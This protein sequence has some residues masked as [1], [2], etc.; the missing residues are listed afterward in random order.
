MT[1]LINE[2]SNSGS[3]WEFCTNIEDFVERFNQLVKT[4]SDAVEFVRAALTQNG[5]PSCT[6]CG[7]TEWEHPYGA[8]ISTCKNCN[9]KLRLTAGTFFR[10][11]KKLKHWVACIAM[12]HERIVFSQANFARAFKVSQSTAWATFHSVATVLSDA[13]N[14]DISVSASIQFIGLFMKRSKETINGL[15]PMSEEEGV[16]KVLEAQREAESEQA[17]KTDD[18]SAIELDA[19]VVDEKDVEVDID[20]DID[21]KSENQQ[22][23]IEGFEQPD[24]VEISFTPTSE[25]DLPGQDSAADETLPQGLLGPLSAPEVK[26]YQSMKRARTHL[27]DLCKETGLDELDALAALTLLEMSGLI[28]SLGGNWFRLPAD[29]R[30]ELEA[31]LSETETV[32]PRL[33]RTIHMLIAI[34]KK[35]HHGISRKYLQNYLT[36]YWCFIDRRRWSGN[37]IWVAA[38]AA[39]YPKLK[40]VVAYVTPEVVRFV[41]A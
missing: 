9:L 11:G 35:M 32:D 1:E 33:Q 13:M 2:D 38:A 10:A 30:A 8:R 7:G 27:F 17:R 12:L 31:L 5:P 41:R 14:Q 29:P 28:V 20:V 18:V 39:N 36:I 3:D 34:I 15:H 21:I 26:L 6:G 40:D 23:T 25:D 22:P 4:E 16:R 24:S 19:Y 37:A